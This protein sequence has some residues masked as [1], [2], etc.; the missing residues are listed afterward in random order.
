V[1]IYSNY[2]VKTSIIL[3]LPILIGGSSKPTKAIYLLF[4]NIASIHAK[5]DVFEKK[6]DVGKGNLLPSD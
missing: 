5:F 1:P 4:K 6:I 2:A 3:K